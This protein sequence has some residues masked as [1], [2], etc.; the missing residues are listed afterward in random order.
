M[1]Q[2]MA[3]LKKLENL[4]KPGAQVVPTTALL[5]GAVLPGSLQTLA[6]QLHSPPNLLLSPGIWG[7]LLLQFIPLIL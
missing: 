1:S 3:S 5:D 2:F 4:P 6:S 7:S